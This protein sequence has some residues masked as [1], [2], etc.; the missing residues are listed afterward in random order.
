[1]DL[2]YSKTDEEFRAELRGWLEKEVPAHGPPPASND[3]EQR[4]SYD[5]GVLGRSGAVCSLPEAVLIG[6]QQRGTNNSVR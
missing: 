6:T 5:T 1:M 4:R 3:W 2:R